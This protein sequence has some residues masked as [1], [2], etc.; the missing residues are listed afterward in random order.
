MQPFHAM[1]ML[2]FILS[3]CDDEK[4]NTSVPICTSASIDHFILICDVE[5]THDLPE[6]GHIFT[7]G[8]LQSVDLLIV[9]DDVNHEFAKAP[10]P[11]EWLD[12]GMKTGSYFDENGVEIF[13]WHHEIP[14]PTCEIVAAFCGSSLCPDR[15]IELDFNAE[16]FT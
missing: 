11:M 14:T 13:I 5:S 15:N 1:L 2:V 3:G 8:R 9:S 10:V 6:L 4:P 16:G 7:G 12:H